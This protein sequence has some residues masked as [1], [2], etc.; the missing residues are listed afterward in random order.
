MLAAIGSIIVAMI[1]AL[2]PTGAVA[3][4]LSWWSSDGDSAHSAQ[5]TGLLLLWVVPP[6]Y[7][8]SLGVILWLAV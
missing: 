1:L 8:V 2:V 3:A 4:L 6:V 7:V 5:G